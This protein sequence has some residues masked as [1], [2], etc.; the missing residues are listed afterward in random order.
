MKRVFFAC[1]VLVASLSSQAAGE[2]R[3]GLLVGPRYSDVSAEQPGV[4][5][6]WSA[7][8]SGYM[9]WSVNHNVSVTLGAGLTRTSFDEEYIDLQ[10][11]RPDVTATTSLDYASFPLLVKLRRNSGSFAPFLVLGPRFDVRLNTEQGLFYFGPGIFLI[12]SYLSEGFADT[13]LGA[14]AGVGAEFWR[15]RAVSLVTEVRANIDLN[16]ADST[17]DFGVERSSIDLLV[18]VAF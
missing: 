16:S 9:E 1:A 17:L 2:I 18:G 5:G 12:P 15:G 7:S 10:G 6:A 11:P 4:S 3:F 13:V 14:S 8:F